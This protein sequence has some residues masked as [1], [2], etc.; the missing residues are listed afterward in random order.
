MPPPRSAQA[1]IGLTARLEIGGIHLGLPLE[2]LFDEL[3]D[4]VFFIKDRAGRYLAV[5]RTLV[6]RC[7]MSE[8]NGLIGKRP[9]DLFPSALAERY[10]RQDQRVV[11]TGKPLLDSLDLHLYP[12]RRR[13]WCLTNKYPVHDLKTGQVIG[14][15]GVSRDVETSPRG[16]KARGYPE[17]ATA[18]ELIHERIDN[19]PSTEELAEV[20]S[21]S[22]RQFVQ[23]ARRIFSLTPY[24]LILKMRIDEAL[25]LLSVTSDSLAEIAIATGFC[26]Q[27]AFSRQFRRFT[28]LPP[29]AFRAQFSQKG[30]S[31]DS[32]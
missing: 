17:L 25:H 24:K 12:N 28:G 20:C 16:L 18:L 11:Q 8:K 30:R 23:L 4:V 29:G 14:V 1:A 9:L 2:R 6:E 32:I 3:P 13:G 31:D 26:D 7:A 19:P 22:H 27:S 15:A 21:L 5:N 10:E